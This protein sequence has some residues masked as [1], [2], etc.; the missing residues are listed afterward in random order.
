MRDASVAAARKLKD[1]SQGYLWQPS[2]ILGQPDTLL[3]KPVVVDP[4]APAIATG[5]KSVAFG[6]L[7]AYWIRVAGP[8][9]F[10]RSD[11]FRFSNDEVAFRTVISADGILG[12]QSG[13]VKHF[14][15]GAS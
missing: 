8:V 3:G 14:I 4:N 12:D 15:G 10:E 9:R 13:V 11:D 1:S 5:A 7:S 6:D 2:M